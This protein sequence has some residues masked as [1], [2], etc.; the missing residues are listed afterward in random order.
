MF[1]SWSS[2][3]TSRVQS[4]SGCISFVCK[5]YRWRCIEGFPTLL[6]HLVATLDEVQLF[7]HITATTNEKVNASLVLS[8]QIIKYSCIQIS[9][10]CCYCIVPR[11]QDF[12]IREPSNCIA[13][14]FYT[15]KITKLPRLVYRLVLFGSLGAA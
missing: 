13:D 6:H 11:I 2:T 8:R 14:L 7:I 10:K 12:L 1:H 3:L 5:Q 4:D 15:Y 9:C